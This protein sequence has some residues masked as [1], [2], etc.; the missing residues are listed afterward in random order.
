[1]SA[2]I[3]PAEKPWL[4]AFDL[5][6]QV[7]LVHRVRDAGYSDEIALGLAGWL[8][9][10]AGDAPDETASNTRARYRRI[11]LELGVPSSPR[12]DRATVSSRPKRR[13]GRSFAQ[14]V[15]PMRGRS[16][17]AAA[18]LLEVDDLPLA[19]GF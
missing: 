4:E 18:S 15:T 8:A 6:R 7:E 10:K 13:S 14:V 9:V 2:K 3:Q 16:R 17:T 5:T 19:S 1:M 12:G 11:L